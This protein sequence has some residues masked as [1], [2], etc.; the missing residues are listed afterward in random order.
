[1]SH[2]V[3]TVQTVAPLVTIGPDTGVP[4]DAPNTWLFPF[5]YTPAPS[6]TKYV[7]LHFQNAILPASNHVEIDLGYGTDIF[8]SA[9]GADFWTRPVSVYAFPGGTIPI[10]YITNG[11][12]NGSV[13][14]DEYGRGERRPGIQDPSALSNCDPFLKDAFYTEPIYDPF[15]FCNPPPNWENAACAANPADIRS[16]VSPSVGMILHVDNDPSVGTYLSTCSVTLVAPDMVITAGHCAP[17]PLSL[18]KSAS[19]IFGYQVNCDGSRPAAYATLVVKVLRTVKQ[20]YADGSHFDYWVLQLKVPPGGLSIP[21]I[22]MRHDLPLPGE[23]IFGLHHPN[24]AVKK[25][26]IPHPGF[27]TIVSS[28]VSSITVPANFSVSGGSS[29]S[30]LFDAAGRILGVLSAGTPCSGSLLSYFPTATILPDLATTIPPPITRDVMLVFDRSGSMSATG[31]S[32]RTK[33]EEARDA[34]SLFVQLIRAGTGNRL[35]LVSFSTAA[36]SPVD[37]ALTDVTN[38]HKTALTGAPPYSGGVVGGLTPGGS[39]TLG[40][41]LD[42]ARLQ[43]PAP[44]VNPRSILLLTD[45]LQNTPPML[46]D[47]E[48]LLT[49]IDIDAI[50]YGTAANLDGAL[51]DTLATAHGGRYA[52]G[53]TNLQLEKFF[54]QAFGNIFEAGLLMDPEFV[55]PANQPSAAPLPFSVCE[56]ERI[57][58][59]VGWDAI[60]AELLVDVTTPLGATISGS[61]PGVEQATGRTWTF[62]RIPL[63]QGGERDGTWKV[64]VYRPGG[65]GEFPPPAPELRYFVNVVAS[66]GAMLRRRLDSTR[67]YTGD[68]IN[69]IVQLQYQLGGLPP[70][71]KLQVIVSKPSPSVGTILSQAKLGAPITIAGDTIPA[72]Q[73]T[74]MA[75]EAAQG[76]PVVTYTDQTFDLFDDP[77]NTA[78]AFEAGG[79]FG[80][81][82]QNLLTAEGDYKFHAKA[83]YGEGCTTTREFLWS[84]HVDV[85]VDPSNT[86]TTV[87]LT[88]T[89]SGGQ[90]TGTVT[91][92][93]RDQYGNDLGPGGGDGVSITGASGTVVTGPIVDNG[94]GSYTVPIAWNPGSGSGP[95][96]VI[97]QPNRPPIVVQ[98]SPAG[99]KKCCWKWW[100]CLGALVVGVAA[101]TV[102][103]IDKEDRD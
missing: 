78:G 41:G 12:A 76:R 88:G 53:N 70:N 47:V 55:L 21:P 14:L 25:L 95:G 90:R 72:R 97:G 45:G 15:W 43:F 82:L 46:A 92:T 40:G 10:R 67:Y 63:P 98:P 31:A 50:G 79:N 51:L 71:A 80:N 42:S 17:S 13:Q 87:N 83:T 30:G 56:E 44:G 64:N 77:A 75:I 38:A 6:G 94:D 37:F 59:V 20:R 22:Q 19:I 5:A 66:G 65:G 23:Q 101:L 68:V 93:P 9:D 49:G 24:G 85:G 91:V 103:A 96:L 1:M 7:I 62:L 16:I 34:A 61:T 33:I 32:G 86:V 8:T 54:A 28:G 60:G 2:N 99:G 58:I 35:G 69:P 81:Q 84:V 73:A 57:T 27:D 89:G 74:L 102:C 11:A 36:S 18:D 26:S 39:T 48:G 100:L 52:Q 4:P 29:G 3:G